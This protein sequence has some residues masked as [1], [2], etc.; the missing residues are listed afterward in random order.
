MLP[1]VLI[2]PA[3]SLSGREEYLVITYRQ[4]V[5]FESILEF[6]KIIPFYPLQLGDI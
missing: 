2:K 1:P 4:K 3:R 5:G 6:D